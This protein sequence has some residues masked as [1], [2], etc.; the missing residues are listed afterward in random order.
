[1]VSTPGNYDKVSFINRKIEF[2]INKITDEYCCL[3]SDADQENAKLI[4]KARK[5][6]ANV[7]II[8]C[9]K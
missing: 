1:M 2:E 8:S 4:A 9:K 3:I 5:E 6:N 7:M